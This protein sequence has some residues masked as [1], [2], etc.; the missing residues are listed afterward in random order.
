MPI[1][2]PSIAGLFVPELRALTRADLHALLERVR[3]DSLHRYNVAFVISWLGGMAGALLLGLLLG[4]GVAFL[5]GRC[6]PASWAPSI[7]AGIVGALMYPLTSA[8]GTALMT[9]RLKAEI[10]AQ[11][12]RD[13][14]ARED[15]RLPE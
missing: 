14:V 2:F 15:G 4:A 8:I 11:L 13:D 3:R 7:M 9:I 5:A 12:A 1:L 6:L 10:N